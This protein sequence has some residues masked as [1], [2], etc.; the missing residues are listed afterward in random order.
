VRVRTV[1][2]GVAIAALAGTAVPFALAGSASAKVS[3]TPTTTA[4]PAIAITKCSP[5]TA[6]ISTLKKTRYVINHGTA[7]AGVTILHIGSKKATFTTNTNKLIKA[8]V[9]TGIAASTDPVKVTATA[10]TATNTTSCTFKHAKK[11]GK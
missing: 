8:A 3:A 9:P 6:T 2:S 7:L 5:A 10:G 4:P 11:S 1:A